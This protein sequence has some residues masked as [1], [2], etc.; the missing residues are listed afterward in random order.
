[1]GNG[2]VSHKRSVCTQQH[3]AHIWSARCCVAF[4]F[5]RVRRSLRGVYRPKLRQ[6]GPRYYY[7][8]GGGLVA[9]THVRGCCRCL[10][11]WWC[12]WRRD[13]S[14]TRCGSS[15]LGF[16]GTGD[17]HQSDNR[18]HRTKYDFFHSMNCFFNKRFVAGGIARRI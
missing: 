6:T 17:Q 10:R 1:M 3:A 12:H 14:L 7:N 4:G 18:K 5:P 9:T 16:A 11:G 8:L 2:G 13:S 15:R